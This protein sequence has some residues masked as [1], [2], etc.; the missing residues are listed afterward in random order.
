MRYLVFDLPIRDSQVGTQGLMGYC[1]SMGIWCRNADYIMYSTFLTASPGS[2]LFSRSTLLKRKDLCFSWLRL[3][4]IR[5][6]RSNR[7]SH[8]SSQSTRHDF[9]V[10]IL[11]E[12][13]I[14][15]NISI[16][17]QIVL[18]R[19]LFSVI[20]SPSNISFRRLSVRQQSHK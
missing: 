14:L 3:G 10:E 9:L 20:G 11:R 7:A 4:L 6:R 5:H 19:G 17:I 8:L 16:G 18:L 1:I 2:V 12:A 13:D 15:V